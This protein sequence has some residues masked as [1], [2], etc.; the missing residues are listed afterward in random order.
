MERTSRGPLMAGLAVCLALGA[1]HGQPARADDTGKKDDTMYGVGVRLRYIHIPRQAL[2]LFVERSGGS[3]SH[4]GFGIE[5]IREKGDM[6]FT[7]GVELDTIAPR[8]GVFIEK[9]SRIPDDPVDY[10]EFQDFSWVAVDVSFIGQQPIIG[11]VLA[12]RYGAGLGIGFIRGE[13]L[14]TDYICTSEDV[15]SCAEDPNAQMVREPEPDVPPV[16]PLI[17]VILGLQ[18]RPFDNVAINIEG[19]L[20]TVPFIGTTAAVLF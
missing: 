17:N 12:L 8:D 18:V 4:P 9:G 6:A 16:F 13:I 5:L 3:A 10:I 20:R 1:M 2:E 15:S 19:G 14:R 7:L 11:D